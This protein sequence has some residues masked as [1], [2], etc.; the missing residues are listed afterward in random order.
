M[1]LLREG[2][3][4]SVP[5]VSSLSSTP[6]EALNVI[7]YFETALGS[8][9]YPFSTDTMIRFEVTYAALSGDRFRD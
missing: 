6:S 9:S 1:S 5:W 7:G 2:R 3:G 4:V 8:N